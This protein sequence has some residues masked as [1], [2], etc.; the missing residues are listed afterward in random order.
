MCVGVPG[1]EESGF[2]MNKGRS[3]KTIC[4]LVLLANTKAKKSPQG[5]EESC[6]ALL[7]PHSNIKM[8]PQKRTSVRASD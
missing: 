2:Y 1:E 3:H 8:V 7:Q 4:S 5:P 6:R